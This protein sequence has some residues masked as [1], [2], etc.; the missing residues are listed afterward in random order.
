MFYAVKS[1]I[2]TSS[3]FR[4]SISEH[5]CSI[6]SILEI[7]W[8][9]VELTTKPPILQ[10]FKTKLFGVTALQHRR[11]SKYTDIYFEKCLVQN[12]HDTIIYQSDPK[13]RGHVLKLGLTM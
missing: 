2:S 12:S 9:H 13:P 3:A 6:N 11:F 5:N 1:R 10:Q 7:M 8:I 4:R